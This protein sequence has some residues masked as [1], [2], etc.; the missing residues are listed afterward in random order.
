M[1]QDTSHNHVRGALEPIIQ[2][3]VDYTGILDTL[4]QADP[5]PTALVW[6]SLRA[7]VGCCG[8]YVNLYKLIRGQ[9]N[10]LTNELNRLKEYED[11]FG[12]SDAMQELLKASYLEIL[13]FYAKVESQCRHSGAFLAIKSLTSFSLKKIDD[14]LATISENGNDIAKLVS[15][16][17]E[18]IYQETRKDTFEEYG[19]AEI[20]RNDILRIIKMQREEKQ[21]RDEDRRDKRKR[22][23]RQWIQG[24]STLNESNYLRQRKGERALERSTA[25]Y[26]WLLQTTDFQAWLSQKASTRGLWLRGGSGTGKSVVCSYVIKHIKA[27]TA[28]AAIAFQYY[29]FNEPL[30]STTVY[31]NIVQQLLDQ[32]YL[33][34]DDVSDEIYDLTKNKSDNQESMKEM[35]VLL[36]SELS[37]TFILLDG[38]DEECVD[39]RWEEASEVVS[40]LSSLAKD[41]T[42]GLWFSSQERSSIN[43]VLGS[44]PTIQLSEMTNKDTVEAFL[45]N[46]IPLLEDMNLDPGTQTLVIE[47]LKSKAR[48]NFLWAFLMIEDIR[49]APNLQDLQRRLKDALPGDFEKYYHQKIQGIDEKHRHTVSKI[50][51]ILCFAKRPLLLEELCEAVGACE[52]DHGRNISKSAPLFRH[53]VLE[54]CAPLVEIQEV[55]EAED[56]IKYVCSLSHAAVHSFLLKNPRILSKSS[57]RRVDDETLLITSQTLASVC[58]VY[59]SQ[60]CYGRLLEKKDDTFVTKDGQDIEQHHLISYAA[61]YWSMHLDDVHPTEHWANLVSAFVKSRHFLTLL[62]VQSLMVEGQFTMWL[63]ISA[64][65]GYKRV[66]PRWFSKHSA[67]GDLLSHQYNEF[68]G[69]WAL[70]L[71]KTTSS[72]G[73]FPGELSRC[74]WGTLGSQS[75]LYQSC[76]K[77]PQPK[78]FPFLARKETEKQQHERCYDFVN[79]SGDALQLFR[80]LKCDD[81]ALQFQVMSERWKM[82]SEHSPKVKES[83]TIMIPTSAT[84][85]YDQPLRM[86]IIGRQPVISCTLDFKFARIGSQIYGHSESGTYEQIPCLNSNEEYI[87][88][89]ANQGRFLAATSRR[90]LSD[91][92]LDNG[93]GLDDFTLEDFGKI[94]SEAMEELSRLGSSQKNRESSTSEEN[95]LTELRSSNGSSRSSSPNSSRSSISNS[96]DENEE[97]AEQLEKA[98]AEMQDK[99]TDADSDSSI[100]S[101]KSLS[102]RES[103]SEASTEPL[104]DEEDDEQWNDWASEAS[105]SD[106]KSDA[107]EDGDLKVEEWDEEKHGRRGRRSVMYDDSDDYSA[108]DEISDSENNSDD[109]SQISIRRMIIRRGL[110]GDDSDSDDNSDSDF[111]SDELSDAGADLEAELKK[112]KKDVALGHQ[113]GKLLVYDTLSGN[114]S[115]IFRYEQFCPRVLYNSPPIFHPSAPLVVWPLGAGDILF[116]N[117]SENTYYIR[118][119][120]CSATRTCHVSIQGKFSHCGQYLHLAALEAREDARPHPGPVKPFIHLSIQ[121]STHRMSKRK[122][123]RSPPRLIYRFG[124]AL[125]SVE[126]LSVSPLPY[127]LTW[128][129]DHLYVSKSQ[130]T[131][132]VIRAPLFRQPKDVTMG[133]DDSSALQKEKPECHSRSSEICLPSSATSRQVHY[134]APVPGPKAKNIATV[135]LGSRSPSGLGG[136]LKARY[137]TLHPLGVYLD[138]QAHLGGWKVLE[139]KPEDGKK[140]ACL[141]GRLQGKFEKFDRTDDCDIVPY[142]Y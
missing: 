27:T 110:S 140:A 20:A 47:E 67:D 120:P 105:L 34:G 76:K 26:P 123:V 107:S 89:L 54:L 126:E 62:Q 16:I 71:D 85:L 98:V 124:L 17:Q 118:T 37:Q 74:L 49:D 29:S 103:C 142:L 132:H 88:E 127:T 64:G 48:G 8:R 51:S 84:H 117:F 14:I 52:T 31:R 28:D 55:K 59:L 119:M 136:V 23:V 141:G 80:V 129:T 86:K 72:H 69:E 116:A 21:I 128:T 32:L 25:T 139:S 39:N 46:A 58:L 60:P 35:I 57:T 63:S 81:D 50:L 44:L 112:R 122:T 2:A 108:S 77:L 91:K 134:F 70:V 130:N 109:S 43:R 40:F 90:C 125:D 9:L 45:T 73:P 3:M 94:F 56:K 11:L 68:L 15:I 5:M 18:R 111:G 101:I 121:L 131:L 113:R 100:E 82:Y 106:F 135:V 22:E 93:I 38:L 19:K 42:A 79:A 104:S 24:M 41:A 92:D 36:I 114:P 4:C 99:D 97:K 137:D 78:S 30:S 7:L 12:H 138:E 65:P 61:K 115:P 133:N 75:F 87:E 83:S 1:E 6:G 53:K 66:F 95:P 102:A 96:D 33:K 10:K 13:R